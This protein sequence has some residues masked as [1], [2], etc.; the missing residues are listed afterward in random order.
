TTYETLMRAIKSA[1]EFIYIEDQYFSPNDAFIDAL[2]AAADNCSRL[3]IIVPAETDNFFSNMRRQRLFETLYNSKWGD[4]LHIGAPMRRPVLA[5]PGRIASQGRCYLY[6]AINDSID[7]VSLGPP[8]RVPIKP[9]FWLW[10]DGELMLATE[11]LGGG[12]QGSPANWKVMRCS[13]L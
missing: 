8:S 13:P 4:R 1:R 2:V 7:A 12:K 6:G 3:V 5:N 10:I 11:F 9:P